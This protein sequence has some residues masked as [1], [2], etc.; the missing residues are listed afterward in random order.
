MANGT[1]EQE[2]DLAGGGASDEIPRP[3]G[4][5]PTAG[6]RYDRTAGQG[7]REQVAPPVQQ[8]IGRPEEPVALGTVCTINKNV[9]EAIFKMCTCEHDATRILEHVFFLRQFGDRLDIGQ[10]N[11]D[12]KQRK[13]ALLK[14][15]IYIPY[16]PQNLMVLH[17]SKALVRSFRSVQKF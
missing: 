10:K 16:T 17:G 12:K 13:I 11:L 3:R 5:A 9:V 1:A 6:D 15:V 2:V 4:E 8:I 7:H 14:S